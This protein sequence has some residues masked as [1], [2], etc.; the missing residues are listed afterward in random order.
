MQNEAQ[1]DDLTNGFNVDD[2]TQN[3]SVSQE[4]LNALANQLRQQVTKSQPAP[5]TPNVKTASQE[6]KERYA[7]EKLKGKGIENLKQEIVQDTNFNQ[8]MVDKIIAEI[9][10]KVK[11]EIERD[12]V[13]KEVI[14]KYAKGDGTVKE[15]LEE[16]LKRINPSDNFE[17]DVELAIQM[18]MAKN[19]AVHNQ[20]T[21]K[22]IGNMQRVA[23][24]QTASKEEEID[25]SMFPGLGQAVRQNN[26]G[27]GLRY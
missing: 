25:Y 24:S 18:I 14:N 8:A 15:V 1:A 23:P 27:G 13:K 21:Q 19:N 26:Q 17:S 2:S 20:E 7:F 22:A 9:T 5:V 4:E 6:E 12:F 16:T 10:P 11:Q 3:S